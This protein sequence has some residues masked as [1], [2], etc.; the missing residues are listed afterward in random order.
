MVP[1][2]LRFTAGVYVLVAGLLMGAP[3]AAVAFAK[4]PSS[5]SAAHSDG[6]TNASD[7]Q[8]STG[9]KKP[10]STDTRKTPDGTD[11]KKDQRDSGQHPST[12]TTNQTNAPGGTHATDE[13]TDSYPVAAVPNAVTLETGATTSAHAATPSIASSTSTASAAAIGAG[14]TTFE[15]AATATPVT[16]ATAA[17]I[18]DVVAPAPDVEP[19]L[20]VPDVVTPTV[21]TLVASVSDGIAWAQY[22]LTLVFGTVVPLTQ[23]QSDLYSFLMGIAGAAPVA[24]LSGGFAGAGPSA[25][26]DASVASQ[27]PLM[28]LLAAIQGVPV[29]GNAAGV[30]QLGGMAPSTVGAIQIGGKSSLPGMAP[31]MP[32]DAI[33]MGDQSS[34]GHAHSDLLLPASQSAQSAPAAGPQSG[35]VGVAILTA[36]G[37][38]P[39]SLA[40]LARIALPGAGGLITLTAAGVRIGYRQ[41]KAGFAVRAAGVAG[42]A[43]P[44]TLGVV[45]SGSLVVIRPGAVAR[46]RASSTGHPFQKVA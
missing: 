11:T 46:R 15:T 18:T 20:T 32:N 9:G 34:F 17:P 27:W 44:G 43:R 33:P 16:D 21:P 36:A 37:V 1:S 10:G 25:A 40:A 31:L 6:G 42:F 7:Q 4:P 38:L 30:A 19:A 13:T 35:T 26:R 5:D 29:A 22:M 23:L 3:G 28:A 2:H 14:A 41:A 39:V 24:E 45:R 8:P 12:G